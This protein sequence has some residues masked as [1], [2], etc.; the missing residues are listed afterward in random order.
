MPTSHDDLDAIRKLIDALSPFDQQDQERIV[1]WACEKLG[2]TNLAASPAVSTEQLL[3][4]AGGTAH[5]PASTNVP[6]PGSRTDI[7]SF[8]ATKNPASDMQFATTVAYYYAFEAPAAQRKESI[9]SE[10]L[11]DACRQLGR[12]R[13]QNPGQTLRNACYNG[14]LDKAGDRGAYKINTVG[15]NLVAVT[16]PGGSA[17]VSQVSK[18]S[19]RKGAGKKSP[20]KKKQTS[21]KKASKKKR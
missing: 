1:R 20:V 2:L 21:K 5:S 19:K 17:G 11:Q 3:N 9:A 7:K 8:V 16:L 18:K 4:P 14:L 6:Q 15:E 10:D 13:L 12:E